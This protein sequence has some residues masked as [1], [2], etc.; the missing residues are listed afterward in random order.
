MKKNLPV[1]N[2]EVN[3]SEQDSIISTTNAKGVITYV[4]KDFVSISGFTEDECIGKNHNMVRHPDMPELAF[5]DL[6]DTVKS[7]QPW[8]GIVKNRCK[9]GDFYW[10]D[11]FVTPILNH[12]G[13]LEGYQSVRTKP[14]REKVT[15]AE[16]LYAN[17]NRKEITAL[18]KKKKSNFA[19]RVS[20]TLAAIQALPLI[21]A[22]LWLFDLLPA[23]AMA[24]AALVAAAATFGANLYLNRKLFSPIAAATHWANEMSRG[25]LMQLIEIEENASV[26]ELQMAIKMLQARL[27]TVI[28]KMTEISRNVATSSEQLSN[29]SRKMLE[30][31]TAQSSDTQMVASAMTEMSATV[32]DVA[33]STEDAAKA[34]VTASSDSHKGLEAM[35]SVRESVQKMVDGSESSS[36]AIAQLQELSDKISNTIAIIQGI[37]NQTNLLALNATI[38]AARAG[39][40]GKGFAVV[41]E[42]VKSL[43]SSTQE[44]T[45]DI[46]SVIDEIR[47]GV[48]EVVTSMSE[49]QQRASEAINRTNDAE[50][51]L[52][53]IAAAVSS[54]DGMNNQ[55][56]HASGEM[57]TV[58]EEISKNIINISEMTNNTVEGIQG[59]ALAGEALAEQ[60]KEMDRQFSVFN[61][62]R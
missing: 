15:A 56:A 49:S 1:T 10:V 27:K 33:K 21:T 4:N 2:H 11:A 57:I 39:E 47:K 9:N 61:S 14:S 55:I 50:K 42:E 45:V 62:G 13:Q 52:K 29:S 53:A 37:A 46:E 38:E 30:V 19:R 28:G 31:M 44:A 34:T 12:H 51:V 54:V 23:A 41:A 43:A 60:V 24:V 6:W 16:Q 5:A 22:L 40:S 26:E 36:Q 17:L 18:P 32:E 3:F 8:R 58:A 48:S 7:G 35:T 59:N 25:N 20:I